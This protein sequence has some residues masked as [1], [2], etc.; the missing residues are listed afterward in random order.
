MLPLTGPRRIEESQ[1]TPVLTRR[2]CLQLSATLSAASL[3]PRL[4]AAQAGDLIRHAIPKT[5]EM[6]PIVGLGSSATFGQ[7]ARGE[8]VSALKDVFQAL[9]DAG[10]SVFDTAPSYGDSEEVAGRL[11]AELGIRERIFWATK[12]NVVG[13]FGR[14]GGGGGSA[15]PAAARAQLETSF[16]RY[17]GEV[18]DLIQVHNV[19]DVPTQFGL[20]KEYKE[21][22][23]VRY[24]GITSTSKGQYADLARWM[25]EEPLDF[26]GIDYAVD[27]T[28][29]A[30][31]LFPIARDRGIAVMVYMPFGRT[32][33]W[34]RVEGHEVPQFA[35]ELGC[36][37]WAQFFLKFAAAHADVTTVTP[38][39]SQA[40][41][42]LDNMGAARGRLPDAT[43]QQRMIELINALPQ[44]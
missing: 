21:A 10:G 14:G 3:L 7:V 25:R 23:R 43:E 18:I 42:M 22:G 8:D 12:V 34:N 13:G 27:N 2:H 28:S 16:A 37:T 19:A 35:R 31:E 33:L 4:A 17:E 26:I 11:V 15:D 41:H 6:I 40:R 24:I 5:G 38:A 39:T 32:R 1:E 9:V 29:A 36:E 44:A 30:D 20:L